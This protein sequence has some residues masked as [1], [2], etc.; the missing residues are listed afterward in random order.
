MRTLSLE[1]PGS[2][3]ITNRALIAASCA[4]GDTKIIGYLESDDTKHMIAGLKKLGIKIAKKGGSLIVHGGLNKSYLKPINFFCGN[5]GTTIR[6]LSALVATREGTFIFD[7]E[8]RMQKRPIKDLV[9]ALIQCGAQVSYLKKEGFPPFKIIS[10]MRQKD[11]RVSGKISSQ[12][13]SGLLFAAPMAKQGLRIRVSDELV[14]KSYIHITSQVMNTFGVKVIKKLNTYTVKNSQ[15]IARDFNVEADASSA[16][17]FWGFSAISQMPVEI[18]NLSEKSL[19][20]DTRAKEY[21]KMVMTAKKGG[22][23]DCIEF[24]DAAMTLACICALTGKKWKLTGLQ[25]LRNKECDR[26]DALE[27]ELRKIGCKAR[28]NKD[29]IVISGGVDMKSEALIKTFNDHRMAMCFGMLQTVMKG[30]KIENAKCVS[31]TFPKFWKVLAQ[32]KKINDERNIVL[33][34]MRGTGKSTLA[35]LLGKTMNR[36]I[37][38]SDKEIEKIIGMSIALFVEKNGWEKFR[39][40]EQEI[41]RKIALN[42]KTIIAT[43]GGVVENPQNITRLRKNGLCIYLSCSQTELQKRVSKVTDRPT[44]MGGKS[45]TSE[46][47]LIL[48]KRIPLYTA[49]ADIEFNVSKKYESEEIE[50]NIK[51][52]QLLKI[53]SLCGIS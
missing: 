39:N 4:K 17:Y 30:I 11:C 16:S 19:Q 27:T 38:D 48:K 31:K 2:K 1:I 36:K 18:L 40:I 5:S 8:E 25:T 35:N 10:P 46:L 32:V 9:D 14:S 23:I 7:G 43:G 49:A 20:P 33:I 21:I 24:P 47:P 34:G 53:I 44:L 22:T 15:Y 37:I 50:K 26:L 28:A 13:L 29:H 45:V 12:F 41:I 3:S 6:F 51:S 42:K 52:E